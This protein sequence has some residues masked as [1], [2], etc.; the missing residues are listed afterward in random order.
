MSGSQ[1]CRQGSFIGAEATRRG[2]VKNRWKEAPLS[3]ADG[4]TVPGNVRQGHTGRDLAE[5]VDLITL[6][7]GSSAVVEWH[8][9]VVQSA[10]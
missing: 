3:A 2:R 4:R 8:V 7:Y 6:S 10:A 1:R 5:L 9:A